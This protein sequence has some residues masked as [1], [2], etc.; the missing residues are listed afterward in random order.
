MDAMMTTSASVDEELAALSR[1]TTGEL[2]ERYRELFGQP[3]RT[4]TR[5]TW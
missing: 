1:M 2:C 5:R 3:V 4:A